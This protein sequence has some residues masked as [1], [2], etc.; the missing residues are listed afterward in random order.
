MDIINEIKCVDLIYID[1]SSIMNVKTFIEFVNSNLEYLINSH[2]KIIIIGAVNYELHEH[3]K[4]EYY[5]LRKYA[6]EAL[7][8]I[9]KNKNIFDI[10]D[11]KRYETFADSRF[12]VE[13][14]EQRRYRKQ[15]LITDDIKLAKDINNFNYIES[16]NGKKII[17]CGIDQ[18]SKLYLH[19]F[20]KK[21]TVEKI[22]I[23][24]KILEKSNVIKDVVVPTLTFGLGIAAAI[25]TPLVI[26][27]IRSNL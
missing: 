23:E 6:K 4:S 26:K 11:Q 19:S 3:L 13:L 18:D 16:C 7:D 2:K 17:V 12:Q 1:T 27:N 9:Y 14:L 25:L 10:H 8:Y 5:H 24:E 20:N 22:I 15:L 21:E